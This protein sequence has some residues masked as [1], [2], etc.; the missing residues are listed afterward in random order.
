M[1][2]KDEMGKSLLRPLRTWVLLR[3]RDLRVMQ[4]HKCTD[5]V[6]RWNLI[7]L[8][9]REP[10]RE[11]WRRTRSSRGEGW[12]LFG[13]TWSAGI[14]HVSDSSGELANKLL[15]SKEFA[16]RSRGSRECPSLSQSQQ[17]C[18]SKNVSVACGATQ[19]SGGG[20]VSSWVLR[21]AN[22]EDEVIA[23]SL[24]LGRHRRS[25]SRLRPRGSSI[26]FL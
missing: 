15:R 6:S 20:A 25:V 23:M 24:T 14:R 18:H 19:Q 2:Q 22:G 13:G 4:V 5:G 9:W 8:L 1:R 12:T 16:A 11:P 21:T 26:G 7:G 3:G 10:R 17:L